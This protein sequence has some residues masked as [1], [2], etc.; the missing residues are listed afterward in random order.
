[1]FS[2]KKQVREKEVLNK[3]KGKT[4]RKRKNPNFS[5]NKFENALKSFKT[6]LEESYGVLRISKFKD[7][8]TNLE[9]FHKNCLKTLEPQ[10][11]LNTSLKVRDNFK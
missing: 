3:T 9:K 6:D 10:K 2:L 8:Y 1:M 4:E 7:F 5:L 11:I